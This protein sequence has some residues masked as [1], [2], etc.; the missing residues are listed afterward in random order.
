VARDPDR[1]I[2]LVCRELGAASARIVEPGESESPSPDDEARSVRCEMGGG[3]TA[4]ASFDA[5]PADRD[6]KQRRFEML[7]AAFDAIAV[8]EHPARRSRPAPAMSLRDELDALCVRAGAVNALVVDANSPVVWGAAHAAG[9]V[10][11]PPLPSGPSLA[12]SVA[13]EAGR[14]DSPSASAARRALRVVR[15]LPE[16]AALRRGKPLR[17]VE[18]SGDGPLIAHAFASIYLLVVVFEP[19]KSFDE[20]RAERAIVESLQ[21]I[22]RLVM[23]LPPHEPEPTQGAGV[24]AMRRPRRR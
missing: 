17:Y 1:F 24:V 4:V 8:E 11:V 12:A 22:E 5:P 2:A 16:L 10:E 3:R 13:A 21:R 7:V 18:R 14:A 19:G 6:E 20:L 9:I 15:G 23:A